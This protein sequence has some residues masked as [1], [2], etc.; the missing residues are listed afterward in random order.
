L[1]E[2]V[3]KFEEKTKDDILVRCYEAEYKLFRYAE[4]QLCQTEII[5]VFK[6]VDDFLT[7][8]ASIMNRRKSR[9]GRSLENHFNNL[10]TL[11]KIPFVVRPSNIDGNPDIVIPSV[12]AYKD[13]DYPTSKL[14]V[15]GVKTTCKERWQ[16]VVNEAKRVKEKHLL[17]L[18]QGISTKQLKAMTADGIHL[19]VPSG[20][21]EK[22]PE[23]SRPKLIKVDQFIEQVKTRLA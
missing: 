18:Q 9:A 19:I 14:F 8:A 20:L 15:V 13:E 5:R 23:D 6:D 12:E 21:H 10:L 2:C 17:T 1:R 22:Y 11:A 4:R 3:T 16:Q 7:T